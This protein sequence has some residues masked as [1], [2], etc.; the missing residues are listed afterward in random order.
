MTIMNRL[1]TTLASFICGGLLAVGFDC[2]AAA[3][4]IPTKTV[5]NG[6]P[7]VVATFARFAAEKRVLA[8]VISKKHDQQ[9]SSMATDFFEAAQKGDWGTTSNLFSVLEAAI[10][11]SSGGWSPP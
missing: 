2:A 7:D 1:F 8:E 11:P 3:E 6:A 4:A 5:T 9:L 10:H